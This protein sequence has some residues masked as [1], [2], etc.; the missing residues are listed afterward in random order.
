MKT[1]I[2]YPIFYTVLLIAFGLAASSCSNDSI[3]PEIDDE[4]AEI[5]DEVSVKLPADSGE[6]GLVINTREIFRKGYSAKEVE[7]IF[8][9]YSNFNE[10]LEID[11][12]TSL[13]VLRIPKED[14]SEGKETAFAS[15][16]EMEIIIYDEGQNILA[17]YY[18]ESQVLDGSNIPLVLQT[19]LEYNIPPVNLRD[20]IPYY[21]Q[22]EAISG[23]G[24]FPDGSIL[25][26]NTTRLYAFDVPDPDNVSFHY[27]YFFSP[28][29]DSTYHILRSNS[30][31]PHEPTYYFRLVETNLIVVA[32]DGV[33]DE[34]LA[35]EFVFDQ[36]PDGWI[37]IREAGT[38]KYL[39][40]TEG[41]SAVEDTRKA[42][43]MKENTNDRFRFISANIEWE[44]TDQG[45]TF[46]QSVIPPAEI[47][48]AYEATIKNCSAGTLTEE[49]GLTK[50]RTSVRTL[51]TKESLQ[52]FASAAL[53]LG[54]KTGIS[55]GV[56]VPG[57]GD[58]SAS[59]EFS[60]E[61][62][63]TTSATT[64]SENTVSNE[65]SETSEV[66][67]TRTLEVP[68]F[69]GTEVYDAVRVIKNARV[70]FT[71]VIRLTAQ[72]TNGPALSG[73]EIMTQLMF[74]FV[75]G[76]PIEIGD[77]F[78]DVGLAGQVDI[79]EMFETETGANDIENACG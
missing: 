36:S 10:T 50:S 78:V 22:P 33:N 27:K 76:V 37:R 1:Q 35:I 13:A 23:D 32:E 28:V 9:G 79:N 49:V 8:P 29:T 39:T 61:I 48:F 31:E 46:S 15:G 71:Q 74:N 67:R 59:M 30:T 53:T 70:P 52:L 25:K 26:A 24:N 56:S 54:F 66:S 14:L 19:Q 64:T 72:Y 3:G 60:S 63:L 17:E 2:T 7:L 16:I 62:A 41:T 57:V 21:V 4:E 12:V 65:S 47:E 77:D 51:E 69:S 20:N 42:L 11:P 5:I 55:A 75:T 58:V 6:V 38:N 45:A 43:R 34:S 44:A 40:I 68:P 18:D 73:D